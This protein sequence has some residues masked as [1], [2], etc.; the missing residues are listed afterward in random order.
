MN[1]KI[2]IAPLCKGA[3]RI[4][5]ITLPLVFIEIAYIFFYLL[6][7][8]P[9]ALPAHADAVFMMLEDTM[10]SVTASLGGALFFDFYFKRESER[11]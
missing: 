2:K 11:D 5:F 10:A 4:I 3:K 8:E 1:G 6:G 7:V 9:S